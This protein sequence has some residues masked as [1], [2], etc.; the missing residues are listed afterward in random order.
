MLIL[1][2]KY[3]F[4][5]LL[6]EYKYN[7]IV[8]ILYL[9][10]TFLGKLLVPVPS[11]AV[12]LTV[13][14][15]Q[16]FVS[17]WRQNKCRANRPVCN[18]L[19]VLHWWTPITTFLNIPFV[20]V[21][22]TAQK[23]LNSTVKGF[24]TSSSLSQRTEWTMTRGQQ[25]LRLH[26]VQWSILNLK[27][28]QKCL[29][30]MWGCHLQLNKNWI[31]SSMHVLNNWINTHKQTKSVFAC[32]F[33]FMMRHSHVYYLRGEIKLYF[34]CEVSTDLPCGSCVILTLIMI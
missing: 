28:K 7:N 21:E 30:F 5:I 19:Y 16:M 12:E 6:A 11:T 34:S 29:T 14:F 20:Y 1:Y 27:H 10:H 31:S 25:P 3:T 26:T 9:K 18:T 17:L 8:L 2:L 15:K 33:I 24:T 32:F 4:V 23:L 13:K 22:A